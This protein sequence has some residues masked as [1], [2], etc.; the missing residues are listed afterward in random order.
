[1]HPSAQNLFHC[2][3][4]LQLG[5]LDPE[6]REWVQ[7]SSNDGNGSASAADGSLHQT[8]SEELE[9]GGDAAQAA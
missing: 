5:T 4:H 1:V 2:H 7:H 6:T 8:Q 9:V 3:A